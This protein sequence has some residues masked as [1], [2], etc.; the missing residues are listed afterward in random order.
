M[1]TLAIIGRPNVGKS[2]FFNRIARKKLAI[3]EDR[4]GVTRDWRDEWVQIDGRDWII[5]DTAGLET[6]GDSQSIEA[7]MTERSR[8]AIDMADVILMMTDAR[9]GVTTT[10]EYF[11]AEL[12][13]TGKP[14]I[15]A[16]NKV[17]GRD[18]MMG[19]YDAYSLGLGEP[20]ALSAE[21][22]NGYGD[23]IDRLEDIYKDLCEKYPERAEERF[24]LDDE[25]ENFTK[26]DD[27]LVDEGAEVDLDQEATQ[28]SIKMA[29]VGRPNVGKS[30]LMNALLGSERMLTGPEAGVTR[31][32]ITVQWD[33]EGRAIRLIDTAGVRRKTK[34]SDDLEKTMIY[35]SFR[36]IR[37][38]H[39]VVLVLDGTL[40][41][42]KQDLAL[43]KRVIDEG[44]ILILAV[45]KWDI[46]NNK[47]ETLEQIGWR[48]E[49]SLSQLK[50]VPIIPISALKGKK[51]DLLLSSMLDLYDLWNKRVQT[52]ELNR[53][54][55]IMTQSHPAP[56]V[57]G[58]PNKVKYMTQIKTRPPTF[59]MWVSRPDA[60]PDSY[61]R[62]ISNG[63]RERFDL[64]A[65]PIR[66]TLRTSNNPYA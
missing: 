46:V 8:A 16:T 7:R 35:E 44:R 58:R 48:I 54:L 14:I 36:A 40:G 28:K 59:A 49:D 19:N 9:A 15:L 5:L 33:Y 32:S 41:I 25:D 2:T 57:A 47:N 66:I 12:R 31:D 4:P 22:G 55:D 37:L 29:I 42:D 56:L 65:V 20:I 38:A 43:A 51:L 11:A 24:N 17:E 13:K 26:D 1:F 6:S 27:I 30:T 64:P 52:G 53:W 50:N 39:I 21:H 18:S 45:N 10:D 34:V 3:V 62:Y 23:F 61:R 60:L 63:L